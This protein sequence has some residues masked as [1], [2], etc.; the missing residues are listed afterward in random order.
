LWHEKDRLLKRQ[1]AAAGEAFTQLV[2]EHQGAIFALAYAKLGNAHDAEDV[3]QEVFVEA[4]RNFHKLKNHEKI[5]G[6]LFKA[7][8][9]R[10]K[11]H[12]RKKSRRERREMEFTRITDTTACGYADNGL[13][14]AI[15][16]AVG[17]LPEKHRVVV[18][19]RH[20]AMLSYA[21]I[22]AM[23][24][25]SKTTVDG[26]LQTAKKE[27]KQVLTKMGIGGELR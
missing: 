3:R 10:C 27:M 14:D 1:K 15:L 7:T 13:A 8:I 9:Y 2:R 4:Y 18:M 19:L 25:L 6:W 5:L 16:E 12:M 23:T 24:G 11:D 22:S 21:D 26:R 17:R 20:F